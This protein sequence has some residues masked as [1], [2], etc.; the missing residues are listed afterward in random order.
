M[1]NSKIS[2]C[3]LYTTKKAYFYCFA[4]PPSY[5]SASLIPGLSLAILPRLCISDTGIAY[6]CILRRT[7]VYYYRLEYCT[8]YTTMYM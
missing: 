3:L 4:I 2:R 6:I 5:W 8:V 7:Y 1:K